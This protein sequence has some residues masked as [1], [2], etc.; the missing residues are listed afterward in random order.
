MLPRTHAVHMHI[1][2]SMSEGMPS[3]ITEES[4]VINRKPCLKLGTLT[5]QSFAVV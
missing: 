1:H 3:V 2:V 5:S 4:E